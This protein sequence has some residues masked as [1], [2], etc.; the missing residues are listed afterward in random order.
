MAKNIGYLEYRRR[1]FNKALT[2]AFCHIHS[3]AVGGDTPESLAEA[4]RLC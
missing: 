1:V 2:E 4:A 3:E